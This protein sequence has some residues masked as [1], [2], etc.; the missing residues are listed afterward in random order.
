MLVS[1]E[2]PIVAL[3]TA[4]T[5]SALALIR[6][7]GAGCVELLAGL[8]KAGERLAQAK[9]NT[10][11]H[12]MVMDGAEA[13]DEVLVAV[14]RAPRSYTG[15]DAAEISCH[16][17][18]PVIRRML[19][20]L[21][22][23][24]F[25]QAGPGE[26]TQRA[27]L[28]GKMDLTRA[29]AVNELVRAQTDRARD[30][31]LQRLSGAVETKLKEARD[32]LIDVRAAVEVQL[33]YPDDEI[34]P[35][36][37]DESV[38]TARRA[39]E[40]LF[41]SFRRGRLY[42]E[43]VSVAITGAPNS[44]K[45]SLFNALLKQERAIVS[46]TPGTTRDYLEGFISLQGIP[47]R[48][49]DTAGIRE[50]QDPVEAEGVRKTGEVIQGAH[51]I[52]ELVDSQIGIA[53]GRET[54]AR[55]PGIGVWTKVDLA[56]AK[57]APEGFVPVSSITGAGIEALE[58]RVVSVLLS[59]DC[60]ESAQPLIDSERQRDLLERALASLS[61]FSDGRD[62]GVSLDLLAVDLADA[63]DAIGE[64][65]GEVTSAEVLERMFGSFCVGK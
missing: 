2:D 23:S 28:N 34:E 32:L 8:V 1:P 25:R 50:A 20:L 7:S 5:P 57:P 61:R 65:T 10:V 41:R 51:V 52:L 38:E 24:G 35:H 26:F 9:G 31:A 42:Q 16:G 59:N 58:D 29:E 15:E 46:E 48:L 6:A 22:R 47:M 17:S 11:H 3:A 13:V 37:Y 39:L 30:L 64:I 14:F 19:S 40:T 54:G 44:G 36:A 18:L 62:K 56:G 49:L 27:F 21:T 43:G 53:A 33:D 60:E 55:L 63:L 45:S 4:P 12:C